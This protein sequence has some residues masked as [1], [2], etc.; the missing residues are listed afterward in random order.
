MN[1]KEALKYY[2]KMELDFGLKMY[3]KPGSLINRHPILTNIFVVALT[4]L[5]AKSLFEVFSGGELATNL[6]ELAFQ[7]FLYAVFYYSSKAFIQNSFKKEVRA[8]IEKKIPNVTN[9]NPFE[10]NKFVIQY[11]KEGSHYLLEDSIKECFA[12]KLKG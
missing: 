7:S 4:F 11:E 5:M 10:L 6:K 8:I 2:L 1:F 3:D 12:Q 9:I